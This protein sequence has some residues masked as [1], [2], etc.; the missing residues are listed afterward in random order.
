MASVR[1]KKKGIRAA[2]IPPEVSSLPRPHVTSPP[3][4]GLAAARERA[5]SP[6][7]SAATAQAPK[8]PARTAAVSARNRG[9]RSPS[10]PTSSSSSPTHLTGAAPGTRPASSAQTNGRPGAAVGGPEKSLRETVRQVLLSDV[11]RMDGGGNGR[12]RGGGGDSDAWR[13][14]VLDAR[15]TRVISSVVGMYDIMEGHVTVVEDLHKARQP[16]PEMEGVY[17]VSPTYESVE[18]I[19]RDFKNPSEALYSKVHLFFLERVPPDLVQSIKQCPTLVS[20]L[21]TFKE[22]N[23]DFLVPEMQS[24]HLDMGSLSGAG[25]VDPAGHFRELYGGRGQGR[26]MASIAQR[27]V[28]LCATLGEFPHIRFAADG[29]GR[30]EGVARTFQANMEEFVSNSPTWS[31]RGQDSRASDGGRAT[32]L[33]LDRADDPL[34]PLM[35]EF[36]YQCL[37]E[38]LLGIQDGRVSYMADTGKGKV[39]KEALLNDSDTLWAEFR[40]A[41][42]GKVLTD[43]GDR[44][45]DLVASNAGAAALIKGE[46]RQ[47]SVEQM[48][49]ATRGLPEFQELSKKMSQHVR[50]SQECMDKL[51]KKNLLRAGAL[52]Q[53]M[54][55]GTDELG[56]SRSRKDILEGWIIEGS[57]YQPGLLE[58]LKSSRAP[59]EMKLRL[60]GIFNT[61]QPKATSEEK[62]RVN[63]TAQ[64]ATSS[65]PTLSGLNSLAAAAGV[66]SGGVGGSSDP[67]GG[68]KGNKNKFFKSLGFGSSK[69]EE[70]N[71]FTHM[72][73]STPLKETLMKMLSGSL[74]FDAFPSLLPMPEEPAKKAVGRS[75][76]KGGGQEGGGAYSGPRVIVFVI[77]GV[78]HSEMRAAY[79]AMHAHGREVVVGGS[80]FLPPAGFLAGLNGLA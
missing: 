57:D 79:E 42:I 28:T 17:L 10:A 40:H 30:T 37:V 47:M 76:R 13:V 67:S 46:G 2:S 26:A 62:S 73:Y 66:G 44:F 29:G 14:M 51:E 7:S 32:L 21:K 6:A 72:R 5:R 78:C 77:G 65:V 18:A 75:I 24:Y 71:E 19:K 23:M 25:E 70:S 52:E 41:H 45:R 60:V 58:I 4:A 9:K 3:P 43:L 50:L 11:V 80:T 35:H 33:L 61:T 31:F 38:D 69:Q 64:L 59:E 20:R 1:Q 36:T 63:R 22:I 56:K 68:K 34:S 27:L 74:S 49:K 54:A 12:A 55:L 39:K 48:A 16:F 8:P 53:T 15:A